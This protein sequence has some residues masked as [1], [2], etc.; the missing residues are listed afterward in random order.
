[1]ME[2]MGIDRD[3]WV[4]ILFLGILIFACQLLAFIFLKAL[5][6]RF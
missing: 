5:I 4:G 2:F 3:Y 1:M 6:S